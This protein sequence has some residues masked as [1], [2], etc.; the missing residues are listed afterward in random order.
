MN[1]ASSNASEFDSADGQLAQ[2]M[3]SAKK[4]QIMN[5]V[6]QEL[7]VANAQELVTVCDFIVVSIGCVFMMLY[8]GGYDVTRSTCFTI[9]C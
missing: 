5:Q 3:I 9:L 4:D 2:G 8:Y 7:A 6:R 1:F